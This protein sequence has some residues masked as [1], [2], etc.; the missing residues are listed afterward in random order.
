MT[1]I[2]DPGEVPELARQEFY[3]PLMAH[4]AIRGWLHEAAL[5]AG[6]DSDRLS[7][8]RAVRAARRKGIQTAAI[9]PSGQKRVS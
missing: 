4:F 6:R 2:L 7:H 5:H 8:P 1:T 9:L 3:G